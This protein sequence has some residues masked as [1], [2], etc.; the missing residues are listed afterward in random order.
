MVRPLAATALAAAALVVTHP[1]PTA[2]AAGKSY[3]KG[4]KVELWVS[5]V[6]RQQSP[7]RRWHKTCSFFCFVG[8]SAGNFIETGTFSTDTINGYLG[9]LKMWMCWRAKEGENDRKG[10]HLMGISWLEVSGMVD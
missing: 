4:H 9:W 7:P 10:K 1:I 2:E 3:Q 8:F 5:K 6:R